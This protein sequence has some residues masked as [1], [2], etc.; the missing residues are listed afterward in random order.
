MLM[1]RLAPC[2]LFGF[3]GAGKSFGFLPVLL[4]NIICVQRLERLKF[5]DT[6]LLAILDNS[7]FS[8]LGLLRYDLAHIK[9][10]GCSASMV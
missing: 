6:D 5:A 1:G 7:L 2:H 9:R 4:E 10:T 3:I 8:T